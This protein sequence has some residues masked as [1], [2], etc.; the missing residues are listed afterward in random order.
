MSCPVFKVV[1]EVSLEYSAPETVE[2]HEI[3]S[4]LDFS[5]WQPLKASF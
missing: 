3:Q 5:E 4:E 2:K 1:K